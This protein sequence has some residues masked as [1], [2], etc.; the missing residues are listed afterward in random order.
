MMPA[1]RMS[2]GFAVGRNFR[3]G[4][5][6]SIC[7]RRI[8]GSAGIVAVRVAKACGLAVIGSIMAVASA[9]R[10]RNADL[11]RAACDVARGVGMIAGLFGVS[12]QPYRRQTP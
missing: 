8:D 9:I 3:K 12:N 5:T 10:R 11:V 1:D 4:S 6:L 2:F 7:D